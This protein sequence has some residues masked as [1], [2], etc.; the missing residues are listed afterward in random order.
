MKNLFQ[1]LSDYAVAQFSF[2]LLPAY[3]QRRF[4]SELIDDLER[5][6]PS[7]H[8]ARY[9]RLKEAVLSL[10][11]MHRSDQRADIRASFGDVRTP[12]DLSDYKNPGYHVDGIGSSD[13][14]NTH[15]HRK[16]KYGLDKVCVA[17]ERHNARHVMEARW[18]KS[19]YSATWYCCVWFNIPAYR[20][21]AM[22]SDLWCSGGGSSGLV[23]GGNAM[24]IAFKKALDASGID[25]V[26]PKDSLCD[27]SPVY[28]FKGVMDALNKRLKAT[29]FEP[30]DVIFFDSHP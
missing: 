11:S 10:L 30:L 4:I 12:D 5:T 28:V 22:V 26:I 8:S 20:G 24:N 7:G 21:F 13:P 19:P 3:L 16:E 2:G 18:Y 23:Y 17:L 14:C 29:E 15:K 6:Y 9:D 1:K 27:T 25:V